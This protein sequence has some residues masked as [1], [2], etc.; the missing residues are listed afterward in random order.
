MAELRSVVLMLQQT[1][2]VPMAPAPTRHCGVPTQ[3]VAPAEQSCVVAPTGPPVDADLQGAEPEEPV[4]TEEPEVPEQL[5]KDEAEQVEQK[6]VEAPQQA[7][8]AQAQPAETGEP[9]EPEEHEEPLEQTHVDAQEQVRQAQ[10]QPEE[11]EE[12]EEPEGPEE[13]EEPLEQTHVE[14]QE[15]ARQAQLEE[16]E[17]P[18]ETLEQA[19]PEEPAS[20]PQKRA[21][22]SHK[23]TPPTAAKELDY[24]HSRRRK[25][26]KAAGDK[27]AGAA[28]RLFGPSSEPESTKASE[29]DKLVPHNVGEFSAEQEMDK[30]SD[31]S[32]EII[33]LSDHD[34]QKVEVQEVQELASDAGASEMDPEFLAMQERC[35]RAYL[36]EKSRS[37]SEADAKVFHESFALTKAKEKRV[38]TPEHAEHLEEYRGWFSARR[39]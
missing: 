33:Y 31:A 9:E 24:R 4:E 28:R 5:D 23:E 18:G 21:A 17:E 26:G 11:P 34:G 30:A 25:A 3:V 35:G 1:I 19:L 10:A 13:H 29:K 14:A 15:Q 27:V 8:Q 37:L 22:W 12:P 20:T 32:D 7:R 39:K 6:H 36:Q 2:W 16:P 38:G